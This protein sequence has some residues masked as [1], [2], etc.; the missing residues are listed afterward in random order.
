MCFFY[1][2]PFLKNAQFNNPAEEQVNLNDRSEVDVQY[3]I[4]NFWN[5]PESLRLKIRLGTFTLHVP[6]GQQLSLCDD[7]IEWA[8]GITEV[9]F[10]YI[11]ALHSQQII[12][13]LKLCT[14]NFAHELEN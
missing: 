11:N 3:D 5:F 8:A 2:H 9:H 12:Q 13:I 7:K 4:L 6:R 10:S 1:L 14:L